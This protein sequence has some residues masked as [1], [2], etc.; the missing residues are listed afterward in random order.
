MNL[1]KYNAYLQY[2]ENNFFKFVDNDISISSG[3]NQF[4]IL[5]VYKELGTFE[6]DNNAIS[7]Y[8]E[9]K[10]NQ[11]LVEVL[12][13]YENFLFEKSLCNGE[14]ELCMVSGATAGL[15]FIFDYCSMLEMKCGLTIGYSYVLF[16]LLAQRY[17]MKLEAVVSKE[18]NKIIPDIPDIIQ[19][20]MKVHV[21]FI[22]L[23]EPLN[24]SGE[25]F[26]E[27]EFRKLLQVCKEYKCF[28][29]IDKCQRDEL[30]IRTIQ[31][32]FSINKVI[33]EEEMLDNVVIVNS[34][35][36]IRNVPGGRMGYII[37]KREIIDYIKYMN[38]ITYWHCPSICSFAISID[39][40][41]QLI[42]WNPS[43]QRQY[44]CDLKKMIK[45]ALPDV[46]VA[47]K[48]AKYLEPSSILEKAKIHCNSILTRFDIVQKNYNVVKAYCLKMN[49]EI[50]RLDGGYNFCIRVKSR[51]NEQQLKEYANVTY[52]IELFT[53]EDFGGGKNLSTMYYWIRISCAEYPDTFLNKFNVLIQVI[54]DCLPI[55]IKS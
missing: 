25:M 50:T 17:G 8:A 29:I 4:E 6:V 15:S 3:V 38:T 39:V 45:A 43:N 54:M 28:L 46:L 9:P 40:L 35:S 22:C 44:I 51:F 20:I 23:T 30:Q 16:E 18:S 37:G 11:L 5:R 21:D 27:D 14:Y 42:F 52:N 47:K 24:P 48:I 19:Y 36:K 53:Q 49:F 10:G 55:T 41:Y 33:L 2:K 1:T 13:Y 32:S 31:K 34:L 26:R 7:S 12:S